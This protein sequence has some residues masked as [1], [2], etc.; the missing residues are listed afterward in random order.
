MINRKLLIAGIIL[1]AILLIGL[2]AT[3]F[4]NRP[5]DLPTLT[6]QSSS[7]L[8]DAIASKLASDNPSFR[9]NNIH[10][11]NQT[12]YKEHWV[13]ASATLVD[14]PEDSEAKHMVYVFRVEADKTTLVGY[15][16]DS[17]SENSFPGYTVPEDVIERANRPQ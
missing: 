6:K 1:V 12:L 7:I 11:D 15:S 17:F 14:E 3:I 5:K 4:L 13:I 16:G 9:A 8:E 2:I 10:I